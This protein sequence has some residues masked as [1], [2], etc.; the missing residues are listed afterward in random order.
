[1]FKIFAPITNFSCKHWISSTY[2]PSNGYNICSDLTP[3]RYVNYSNFTNDSSLSAWNDLNFEHRRC[4]V[5]T[6]ICNW[7]SSLCCGPLYGLF[8]PVVYL[9]KQPPCNHR[10]NPSIIAYWIVIRQRRVWNQTILNLPRCRQEFVFAFRTILIRSF[11]WA[12]DVN[13]AEK[14]NIL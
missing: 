11:V 14:S 4:I 6:V 13:Y 2:T 7:N 12:S 10:K 8:S 1:M 9:K 5:N 3:I